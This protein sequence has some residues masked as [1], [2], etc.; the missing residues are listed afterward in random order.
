M[1][2]RPPRSTRTATLFPYTTLFRSRR[3]WGELLSIR[4]K[5]KPGGGGQAA[6]PPVHVMKDLDL[7]DEVERGRESFGALFPLGGADFTRMAD[8]RLQRLDIEQQ[9][10]GV[11]AHALGGEIEELDLALRIADEGAADGRAEAHTQ[12]YEI[13]RKH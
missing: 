9:L 11:A 7:A 12:D 3:A 8:K 5:G 2:R 4:G 6:A 10:G 1:I 13:D